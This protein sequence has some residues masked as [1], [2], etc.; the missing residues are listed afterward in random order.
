MAASLAG[1]FPAAAPA[2][3]I[4]GPVPNVENFEGP[5]PITE[6]SPGVFAF[7]GNDGADEP[8][9]SIVDAPERPGAATD[10]SGLRVVYDI[11]SGSYGGFS[12]NLA[13]PQDWSA[14]GG[15]SFWVKGSGS[16]ARV[17]FE[18]KDGGADGENAELWESSFIDD[19]TDWREIRTPF[20]A[21]TRRTSY[22]PPGAPNDGSLNLTQ[23]W[24]WAVNLPASGSGTML[25]DDA[26]VYGQATPQVSATPPVQ[27]VDAGD[28]ATVGI[29]LTTRNGQPTESPVTVDWSLGGPD[30]TAV[31]G[32]DYTDD[33]GTVTF[34]AGTTSGTTKTFDVQTTGS[35]RRSTA[36][37][38]SVTLSADGADLTGSTP[39]VV[40][41]ARGMR[42][43]DPSLPDRKRVADLLARM[44]LVEKVGQMTQAE[45]G[46]VGNGSDITGYALGSLL[47]GGGS[48]PTPNTPAGWADMVDAFQTRAL[49]TR[50]QIPLIYGV[51]SVHGHNNLAGATV[52]PHNIGL[53]ATRDPELIERIGE[54]TAVETR[55]TGVPWTFAPCLC[56]TEDERWGRSYESYGEEPALVTRMATLVRGLQRHG[57]LR[58]PTAVLATAK[59]FL[60]DGNTRFGSGSGDYTIDQ[61]VTHARREKIDALLA[62]YRRA[63]AQ[64]VGTVMPSYSSLRIIGE[65][66]EPVKM[67]ARGDMI[68]GVLKGD[69]GFR[70]FVISDWAGIDQIPGDY[71]SDVE[72]SINAGLD[73]VMVPYDYQ[74]FTAHLIDLA[75]SGDVSQA[76]ID[77]AV[78]R[79]LTQKFRLGLFDAPFA[80]RSH[81]DTIGSRAHRA[82]ARRA[83]AQSQVLLVNRRDTLPLK[84]SGRIYVAGS[85]ADDVGNQSGGWTLTWQGQS[86]DLPG[87]TSILEGMRRVAPHARIT[88]SEDASAPRRD[89]RTGVVVVGETPYAEGMGDV[90]NGHDLQL[91]VDDRRAVN[92]VCRAMRCVVLDVSG[93]P[94]DITGVVPRA[95]AVVA[96][97]LPG[98]EGTGVAATLFGRVPF[99]GRLPVTWFKAESQLPINVGDRRYDPLFAYGWGLRTDRPRAR[100]VELRQDLEGVTGARSV[101][102]ALDGALT[103]RNWTRAGTAARPRAVLVAVEAAARAM[104]GVQHTGTHSDLL[105]SVARDL[106]QHVVSRRGTGAM[107]V[108]ARATSLAEHWLLV[109]RPVR[110]VKLLARAHVRA[111]RTEPTGWRS[112]H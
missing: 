45:R 51:D 84:P 56:V 71:R 11:P 57:Q 105:V 75:K 81:M 55:A 106:V 87:G 7:G 9:L 19:F 37:T 93:R 62:P 26:M 82:V 48:T 88:F 29:T 91:S 98:S 17:Q 5:S 66:A 76:R 36:K 74:L 8:E 16:A 23:M 79:I 77:D 38:I 101:L 92:R 49:A 34:G 39:S 10:N 40:I 111:T 18:I 24:G 110:A 83:V 112:T 80:D 46:A 33:S 42:Y 108:T 20:S 6:Q 27:L 47:S 85:N 100:L 31:A 96:S 102:R 14:Y 12:D 65:E 89:Y 13:E 53:G 107:R 28:T 32:T 73:M 78:T 61:G 44:T 70:G 72:T 69:L 50:L 104:R 1:V 43:L 64:G 68:N 63:I 103:R 90:G 41:N 95:D 94:L 3:A 4:S 22:Q 21:F 99:T 15:F 52:F 35:D 2:T 97:W 58:R 67:H 54:V 86:G 60:G 109:G 59:H 25:F 30:D